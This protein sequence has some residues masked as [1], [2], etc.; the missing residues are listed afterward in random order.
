MKLSG[1]LFVLGVIAVV[2][3]C[4]ADHP[5]CYAGEYRSCSCA[6]G[7]TGYQQ[8]LPTQDGYG[9]CPCDG[10][11]PIA[12]GG[13][14]TGIPAGSRQFLE[15]CVADVDCASHVCGIFPTRGNKCSK[16]CM[17]DTE[18][19]PPSPGCNPQKICRSP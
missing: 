1:L 5:T 16:A 10:K 12:D 15:A 9:A 17:A 6:N 2:A 11:T 18:C 14:D 8:C 3:A 19:P 4:A 7:A 13:I